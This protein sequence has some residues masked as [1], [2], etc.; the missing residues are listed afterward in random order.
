[1]EVR[2]NIITAIAW[3]Q[4]FREFDSLAIIRVIKCSLVV[5]LVEWPDTN[6]PQLI[7]G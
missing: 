1:M 6:I 7:S 5:G 4:T 2:C 3:T